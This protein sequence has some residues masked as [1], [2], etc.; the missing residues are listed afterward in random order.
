[1]FLGICLRFFRRL[2]ALAL[3]NELGRLL[4]NVLGDALMAEL[5]LLLIRLV[6][7]HT[8]LLDNDAGRLRDNV[9]AL[10][11]VLERVFRFHEQ[12]F[13]YL[14]PNLKPL[15]RQVQLKLQ[16]CDLFRLLR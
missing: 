3:R 11:H 4:G 16:L 2:G 10:Q 1:M 12:V 8:V 15:F 14:R 6:P 13:D 7:L 9:E 5:A